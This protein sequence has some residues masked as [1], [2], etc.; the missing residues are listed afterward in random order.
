MIK[1]LQNIW[2]K[3]IRFSNVWALWIV[4]VWIW[5]SGFATECTVRV[6][7]QNSL[8]H[9]ILHAWYVTLQLCIG[10]YYKMCTSRDRRR[11]M[12]AGFPPGPSP[13][14]TYNTRHI[15]LLRTALSLHKIVDCNSYEVKQKSPSRLQKKNTLLEPRTRICSK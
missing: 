8:V 14:K 5:E 11:S 13:L 3:P 15:H 1:K 2:R 4:H 9:L 10:S 6:D 7:V 12:L